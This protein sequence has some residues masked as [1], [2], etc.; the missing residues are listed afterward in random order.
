[1]FKTLIN[2]CLYSFFCRAL[3]QQSHGLSSAGLMFFP[4]SFA[5]WFIHL[6]TLKQFKCCDKLLK[7][8]ILKVVDMCRRV[9]HRA[10]LVSTKFQG[11]MKI[12]VMIELQG[13][14]KR[15]QPLQV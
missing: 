8:A 11:K 13:F 5:P 2:S 9:P 14:L 15:Q 4:H 1:M 10:G 12:V 6:I 3:L 7:K